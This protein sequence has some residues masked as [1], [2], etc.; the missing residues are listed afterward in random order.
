MRANLRKRK[1][2]RLRLENMALQR[3]LQLCAVVALT[4]MAA[5]GGNGSESPT[6]PPPPPPSP[7][8]TL[9]FDPTSVALVPGN[10]INVSVSATPLNG[11]SSQVG[12]QISGLPT[13]VSASPPSLSL[14]VGTPQVVTLSALSTTP[15]FSG[16]L[17]FTGTSGSLVIPAKLPLSIAAVLP[18]ANTPPSR[19]R[20]V[21]TDATTEYFGSLNAH[22][23]VYNPN[24][25]Q[26]YVS[27][28][29]S[30]H[31]FVLDAAS[32]KQVASISV[33]GAYGM[34][35]TPDHKTL[36]VGTEIGDVYTIDTASNSVSNRYIA[37]Q[38][39]PNGFNALSALVLS[40]GNVA[41]LGAAGGIPSVDGSPSFAVWSPT[42]NSS[43]VYAT[44][45]G[46]GQIRAPFTVVCGNMMGNIGGFVR[47]PDRTKII[48][49]S[50]D[51]DDTLCQVDGSTGQ[52]SSVTAEGSFSTTHITISPDGKY[53]ILPSY[54]NQVI[55]YN[56][57]TL[58]Q[59]TTFNVSGEVASD[60]GMA[61]S[62]DSSTLFVPSEVI[63]YAYSLTTYE[64]TGWTPNIFLTPSSGGSAVGPIN[65][66]DLQAVDGTGLFAGPMEE[67][68]GFIDTAALQTGAVGT[69]YTNAYL[70][71]AAGPPSGG[72][73]IQWGGP[74]TTLDK[75][76]IYVGSQTATFDSFTGDL[77]NATTPEGAWGPA[78]I[79]VY[80]T[81]GGVQIVPEGFSYGPTVL[82][83]TPNASTSDGG[84]TG[85]IYGYGLGPLTATSIPS[86]LQITVGGKR[87]VITGFETNAY[88]LASP[89]FQLEAVAY[90][91][92]PGAV[93][94]ADVTVTNSSGAA[95]QA[96][97]MT[98]LPATQQF[99]LAGA[100]LVQGIYDSHNDQY[101]FTDTDQV[102]V[103]SLSQ[104]KWLSP[105]PI[106][107]P[108]GTTQR[109]WGIALSPDGSKLAISDAMAGVIYTL[110]PVNPSSVK[111]YS[112]GSSGPAA[113]YT[114]PCGVAIS[115]AG[116]VYFAVF[117]LAGTGDQGFFKLN[118]STGAVTSYG[119][120]NPGLGATDANLRT[121]ISSDN[122][123]VY[124]ND[125]GYVF[126]IQTATDMIVSASDNPGCCYGDYD[127]TL[128][129][130]QQQFE[131][132]SFLYD[133]TLDAES[134][135]AL[136]D[137]EVLNISYVYGAKLAPDGG[138]LFQPSTYGIDVLDGRLGNLVTR[139]SVPFAL[140]TNYD[141]LVNDGKD[142]TL[143]AITGATGDGI[144]VLN[145]TSIS[146]PAP[147]PYVEKRPA[148]GL[149]S[150]QLPPGTASS[151]NA[152][153]RR[154]AAMSHSVKHV[155][156][157]NFPRH[158]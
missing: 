31:V 105:I 11:F 112:I 1:A 154:K 66:P 117:D 120:D 2:T 49:G 59:I 30:N 21:R 156:R 102:R 143:I 78:D 138:L 62:A 149:V 98:Y 23:I 135:Y 10:A 54:P 50:I 24:T 104:G 40:N 63:V 77:V 133:A 88:G 12:V 3:F 90:T 89:P 92:P 144:A 26:F 80:T 9:G 70:N 110:D 109:L 142:N 113:P 4:T 15:V 6:P 56:A 76:K 119:Y 61:V 93:G 33:P 130:G 94:S 95:I 51:S 19:T 85:V 43:T 16:S 141:A 55:V 131:A 13:G 137:R 136:N 147:L 47:S 14:A 122:S 125:D 155:T 65:N 34:D 82:E 100:Q 32:E 128:A 71:P 18:S 99:P 91:I 57:Q 69:G 73:D 127:L 158:R 72:T 22:W 58:N 134:F 150:Q 157:A 35:D 37:S 148:A 83:V 146:E 84:G 75:N 123:R 36:Y 38:I 97:G 96:G 74:T 39:G 28:P 115:D 42:Q 29:Q 46:A 7:S 126:S 103:F 114:F 151:A 121:V 152:A 44:A 67:G 116:N 86:D 87:A 48:I 60:V 108:A 5:C 8:F 27:D 132:S 111:T 20:Y 64:Q 79:Y 25:S 53:I 118:T 45:Y 129:S 153:A 107:T 139:I 124:F 81:D 52:N 140:S 41:L 101:Y 17:T 68:V 106:P 145:L